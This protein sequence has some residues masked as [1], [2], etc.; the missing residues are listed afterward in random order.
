[1]KRKKTPDPPT[2]AALAIETWP[3]SRIIPYEANARKIPKSAV[4][5]VA[6]SLR[7]FG[8]RQPIVVDAAGV[9]VVGHVRRLGAIQNG[10]TE[11]PVHVAHDLTVAQLKAYRLMDNRAHDEASWDKDLLGT[12]LLD[13]KGLDAFDLKLTGFDS[14][15]ITSASAV[16]TKP[17]DVDA[18]ALQFKVL[19][20]C[21]TEQAQVDLLS[22]FKTEGLKCRAL[23]S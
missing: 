10:W 1:M 11:A 17:A 2:P 19:I 23:I 7:E 8:W 4:D 14:R 20:E 16:S 18:G 22:R 3:I 21:D 5:K 13:L 12:E 15:E 9:I 6:L